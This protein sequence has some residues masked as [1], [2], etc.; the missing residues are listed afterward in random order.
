MKKSILAVL[1]ALLTLGMAMSAFSEGFSDY[2]DYMNSDGSYSYYFMQG[3]N[4]TMDQEWYQNTFVKADEEK[5]VFYHRDSFYR[6]AEEG[7]DGGGRLF[8]IAASADTDFE[9]LPAYEYIGYDANAGL[10]YY[11]ILPTDYP[12]YA[13]DEEIRAEYDSLWADVDTVIE[14][15][16]IVYPGDEKE[17]DEA[18]HSEASPVAGGYPLAGGW[19]AAEDPAVPDEVREAL[20][21][22]AGKLLGAEYEPIAL[23]ATQVVAGT[24]YCLLCKV[25]PVYPDPQ[26]HFAL[27]YLYMDLAGGS[28]I[29]EVKDI[30]I[31]LGD[32]G[33]SEDN[34]ENTYHITLSEDTE[35]D[36]V[37]ECPETARAGETVFI[38]IAYV[39][40]ADTYVSVDGDTEFGEFAGGGY[41][42]VMPEKDVEVRVWAVGNGLA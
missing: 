19:T 3:I 12:A 5:A 27:V 8:T 25:T 6:Y 22:A 26:S 30:E 33:G 24:N 7:I 34:S 15:I 31:G 40:D 37:Y 28:K 18:G 38:S 13:E 36:L 39:T 41:T 42:F 2:N 11:V 21:A 35:D 17:G 14:S 10:H 4:V 16:E 1:S 32:E 29:L 9:Q 23:L 20:T